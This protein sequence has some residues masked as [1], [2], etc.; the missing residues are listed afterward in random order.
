MA[1]LGC[2]V[3]E[4]A[5]DDREIEALEQAGIA[6]PGLDERRDALHPVEPG[7]REEQREPAPLSGQRGDRR[8][9]G[10]DRRPAGHDGL[11][12]GGVDGDPSGIV[13]RRSG[14]DCVEGRPEQLPK[15]A[16]E[17][18]SRKHG[19]RG[20]LAHHPID[21]PRAENVLLL[22]ICRG[23]GR[24]V[25]PPG[26]LGIAEHRVRVRREREDDGHAEPAEDAGR[27]E[28]A[29]VGEPEMGDVERPVQSDRS[30]KRTSIPVCTPI[31]RPSGDTC[32][33]RIGGAQA[34]AA[35]D[36][37]MREG[38]EARGTTDPRTPA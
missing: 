16:L 11:P 30:R 28:G 36:R 33:G 6:R 35:A 15:L 25:E 3:L 31:A 24:A 26:G 20:G 4:I 18:W 10:A 1:F 23:E 32:P 29:D 13:Q 21:E 8:G 37:L 2:R 38:V 34:G 5:A 14:S 7:D 17:A 9:E 12:C 27:D 19:E 22:Q